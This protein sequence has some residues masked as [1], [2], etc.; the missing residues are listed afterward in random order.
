MLPLKILGF[1]IKN[2][3]FNLIKIANLL[4]KIANLTKKNANII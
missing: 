3:K 1:I 2:W 4:K